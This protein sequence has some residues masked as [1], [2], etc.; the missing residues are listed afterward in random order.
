MWQRRCLILGFVVLGSIAAA[1]VFATGERPIQVD[2][3][4]CDPGAT[5]QAVRILRTLAVYGRAE[6]GVLSG[7]NIGHTAYDLNNGYRQTW[8]KLK[9]RNLPLPAVMAVDFGPERVPNAIEIKQI[10]AVMV[11]HSRMGGIVSISTHPPNPWTN[12]NYNDTSQRSVVDLL[13]PHTTA[14]NRWRKWQN[15]M[16]DL[17]AELDKKNVPVLFRPLHEANGDWFWWRAGAKGSPWEPQDFRR[18]WRDTVHFFNVKRNLHNL[19]WVYSANAKTYDAVTPI[20]ELYPGDDVVDIV[21][22]DFYGENIAHLKRTGS[23]AAARSLGKVIALSEFGS[24]PMNGRLDG[25][26]W[27]KTMRSTF[28][29]FAYFVFWHSWTGH[30][31]AIADLNNAA[32]ILNS[33]EVIN[34][35]KR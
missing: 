19:V 29:H 12:G 7:Q 15:G 10:A 25:R 28:P 16:A 33:S 3:K 32:A 22:L 31:V 30:D 1:S 8:S 9:D 14:N 35:P 5:P 6:A 27:V 21:A 23:Y 17:L 2:S 18:L 24:K 20:T 11:E 4:P 26:E 13:T 34:L